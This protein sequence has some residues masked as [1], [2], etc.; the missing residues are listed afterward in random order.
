M[1]DDNLTL[2]ELMFHAEQF[3]ARIESVI[4]DCAPASVP[5]DDEELRL[6]I[7][8]CRN[9][10]ALLQADLDEDELR[11]ENVSVRINFRY[12][13]ICLLWVAFRARR[14]MNRQL[15]RRLVIIEAGFTNLL[16]NR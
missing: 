6:K 7:G 11:I 14:V 15:F 12:L 3:C 8:A 5:E 16:V 9:I 13:V 4:A 2:V 10:L 1:R